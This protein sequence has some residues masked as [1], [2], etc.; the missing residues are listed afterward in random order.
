MA[1]FQNVF[2]FQVY[3]LNTNAK[4]IG[5]SLD[6]LRNSLLNHAQATIP[7]I[8]DNEFVP[9]SAKT[10]YRHKKCKYVTQT[11]VFRVKTSQNLT[12]WDSFIR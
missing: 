3:F 8:Y 7:M 4:L 6:L 9:P 1:V 5:V 10:S 12:E 2:I 11:I